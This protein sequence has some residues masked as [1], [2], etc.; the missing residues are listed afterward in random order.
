VV[1]GLYGVLISVCVLG[2]LYVCIETLEFETNRAV[3]VS[4]LSLAL[5]Q[6]WHVLNMR[7]P[8]SRLFRNDVARSPWIWG[9]L[10]VCVLLLLGAVYI[11]IVSAALD[12]EN[13]GLTGW[14]VA[15][16]AS[17]IPLIV[18]QIALQTLGRRP[19]DR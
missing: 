13:P 4:F 5:A 8:G 2:A 3:T 11:P 7:A 15:L 10:G 19:R 12:T 16:G 9:A 17:L 6:L 14:G 1:I 18:G